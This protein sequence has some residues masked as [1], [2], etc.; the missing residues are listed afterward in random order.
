MSYSSSRRSRRYRPYNPI[1]SGRHSQRNSSSTTA[2]SIQSDPI[3]QSQPLGQQQQLWR[4]P[5]SW[6]QPMLTI[7]ELPLPPPLTLPPPPLTLPQ[8]PL[9]L[10]PPPLTLPPP[11][12]TPPPL[13]PPSQPL[14]SS[15]SSYSR[16]LE[17]ATTPPGQPIEP[18]QSPSPYA[19][20]H[21]RY[22]SWQEGINFGRLLGAGDYGAVYECTIINTL[23]DGSTS[24]SELLAVKILS[25][26]DFDIKS[27][28]PYEAIKKMTA[29]Y[30]LHCQLRHDNIVASID[31]FRNHD[32]DTQFPCIRH[33]HFMELCNGNLNQLLQQYIMMGETDAKQW[34]RQICYGL[35]YLHY[36]GICHLD[37][38]CLNILYKGQ[39]PDQALFKL[40]DYGM[41]GYRYE[42]VGEFGTDAYR[43]P[44]LNNKR[45]VSTYPCDIWSLG[46]TLCETL[47]G[48]NS[49]T[50]VRQSLIPVTDR[51]QFE[52]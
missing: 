26:D 33:L 1:K 51:I 9:K 17:L 45:K 29:E 28:T 42:I 2:V 23:P 3:S 37:I 19:Y 30:R 44:E 47:G 40:A 35:Q 25:I 16:S 48:V 32:P 18:R 5:A 50:M 24:S 46:V 41:A 34:F 21:D 6:R 31:M 8:S 38:K 10:S 11:P 13:T 15:S 49:Q 36:W 27:R 20:I 4:P 12:L 43:A 39:Y 14:H 7:D 52:A 22:T